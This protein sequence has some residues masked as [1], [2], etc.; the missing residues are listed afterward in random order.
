MK[1]LSRQ[2][3]L[4]LIRGREKNPR[5]GVREPKG[6]L[7]VNTSFRTLT[8]EER[9]VIVS[10]Y[11]SGYFTQAELAKI[12]NVGAATISKAVRAVHASPR[13]WQ[14]LESQQQRGHA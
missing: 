14:L 6:G 13:R 9:R 10:W 11:R 3:L 12:F 4:R 8:E 1:D 7:V 2:D 5:V